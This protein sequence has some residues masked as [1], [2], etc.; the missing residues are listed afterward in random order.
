M[1]SYLETLNIN[2]FRNLA[3]KLPVGSVQSL[4]SSSRKLYEMC[5]TEPKLYDLIYQDRF[6]DL[7]GWANG[8][9]P[10]TILN[11]LY[12]LQSSIIATAFLTNE[13]PCHIRLLNSDG[14]TLTLVKR[15][16]HMSLTIKGER[17]ARATRIVQDLIRKIWKS[18]ASM[19]ERKKRD[20]S[21]QFDVMFFEENRPYLELVVYECLSNGFKIMGDRYAPE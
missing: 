1:A 4:C 20:M 16:E 21:P 8:L 11:S 13:A 15:D 9:R 12:R 6:G 5:N 19:M 3:R 2:V 18:T 17:S 14:Y 7:D 10:K